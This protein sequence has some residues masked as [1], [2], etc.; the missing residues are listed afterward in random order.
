M[1]QDDCS[2]SGKSPSSYFCLPRPF[3][4]F[5]LSYSFLPLGRSFRR[6]YIAGLASLPYRS[7]NGQSRYFRERA[8]LRKFITRTVYLFRVVFKIVEFI[9]DIGRRSW[10]SFSFTYD[11]YTEEKRYSIRVSD[12]LLSGDQKKARLYERCFRIEDFYSTNLFSFI[13]VKF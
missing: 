2:L 3:L 10:E 5:I 11:W 13:S 1:V 8:N 6:V 9:E 4:S 12:F 7:V